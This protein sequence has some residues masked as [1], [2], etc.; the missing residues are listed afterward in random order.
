MNVL[1]EDPVSLCYF[2]FNFS[3]AMLC[4]CSGYIN[5]N[6]SSS[7]RVTY[8]QLSIVWGRDDLMLIDN[9]CERPN[10]F[11]FPVAAG[12]T[13]A[14]GQDSTK[15]LPSHII[16]T[17]GEPIQMAGGLWHEDKLGAH[18]GRDLACHLGLREDSP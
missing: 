11:W 9:H 12:D 17:R 10:V 8:Q 3:L 15:Q 18:G 5:L 13:M 16:Q 14:G 6:P 2:N 4:H 7:Q 1:T